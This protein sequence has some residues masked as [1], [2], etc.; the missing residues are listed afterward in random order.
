MLF[1]HPLPPQV[2]LLG[3]G[4]FQRALL[5][6]PH[7]AP[8]PMLGLVWIDHNPQLENLRSYEYLLPAS[9]LGP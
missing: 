8:I 7:L 3:L 5:L 1:R 2:F 6:L 4:S 9:C